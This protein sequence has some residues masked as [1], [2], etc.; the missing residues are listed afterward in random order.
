MKKI[1]I[2]IILVLA[3][4]VLYFLQSNLFT[5]FKIAGI[6][7]N[8]FVI[9]VLFI[10]LYS[11]KYMGVTYGIIFGLLLDLFIGKKIGITA[12]MLGI[13]GAIGTIFDKNFSKEN[14]ITIIVMVMVATFVFELGRCLIF[15]I[16][17]R[18]FIDFLPFI[19]ILLIECFYN[20]ILT[21]ILYPLIRKLGNKVENEYKGNKILTRYF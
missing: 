17:N 13:V 8:M 12:I 14:R 4:L 1:I 7:P 15:Y 2:N 10:G 5:W 11:N 6:M 16:I 21:I 18:I 9:L 3:F 19:E 20:A